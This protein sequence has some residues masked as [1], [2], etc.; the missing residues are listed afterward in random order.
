MPPASQS[1]A[2]V[3]LISGLRRTEPQPLA[4]FASPIRLAMLP[5]N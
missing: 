2:G 3:S 4:L 1:T 5:R